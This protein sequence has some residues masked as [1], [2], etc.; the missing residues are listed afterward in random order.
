MI[1]VG[2]W[3]VIETPMCI[4]SVCLPAIFTLFRRAIQNGPSSLLNSKS[5]VSV[6]SSGAAAGTNFN[7]SHHGENDSLAPIRRDDIESTPSNGGS[8]IYTNKN[9]EYY[10]MATRTSSKQRS[11]SDAE[12]YPENSIRVD[13]KLNMRVDTKG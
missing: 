7:H 10:A 11:E 1:P 8:M 3:L 4:V 6:G 2:R 5:Y 13:K 12:S 9:N